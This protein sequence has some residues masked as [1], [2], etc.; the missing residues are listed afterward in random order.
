MV[1]PEWEVGE[2]RVSSL[3]NSL[4]AL[5]VTLWY[6]RVSVMMFRSWYIKYSVVVGARRNPEWSGHSAARAD[7]SAAGSS[8][9]FSPDFLNKQLKRK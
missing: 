2:T 6:D 9:R 8:F 3:F 5:G 1:G 7:G 4:S